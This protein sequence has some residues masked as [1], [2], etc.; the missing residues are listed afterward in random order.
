[1]SAHLTRIPSISGLLAIDA[2]LVILEPEAQLDLASLLPHP[3]A[4]EQIMNGQT[5]YFLGREWDYRNGLLFALK[6]H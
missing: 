5:G 4:W 3:T 2:A 6:A 1:M